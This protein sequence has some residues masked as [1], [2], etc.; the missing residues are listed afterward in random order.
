MKLE[1][2]FDYL[3]EF[4][5]MGHRHWSELL[6]LYP[7]IEPVWKPCEAHPRNLEPYGPHSD[8]AIQGMLYLQ[9][10]GLDCACYNKLLFHG[11]WTLGQNLE[12]ITLLSQYGRQAGADPHQ[13]SEAIRSGHYASAQQNN[14]H[15]AWEV[16]GFQAVPSYVLEDGRHL[17][18]V[19]GVGVSKSQLKEFLDRVPHQK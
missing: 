10:K 15:Y 19:L 8:L 12:N 5:L 11:F 6:P 2:Y 14:N 4:C 9:E 17:E 16:M 13:F 1:I 3:C 18:S 7:W